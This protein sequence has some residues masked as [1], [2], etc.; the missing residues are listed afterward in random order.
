MR[1]FQSFVFILLIGCLPALAQETEKNEGA[2]SNPTR[3]ISMIK[4]SDSIYMFKGKGGNI[5]I[6]K[7]E[8]GVLM[9]D[10]QF[11]AVTP[12]ILNLVRSISK[13]PIQYLVNTHHHG[14]HTGGNINMIQ[15]GTVVYSHDNVRR[16]LE[17]KERKAFNEQNQAGFDKM[18]KELKASGNDVKAREKLKEGY[19]ERP[20]YEAPE[21]TFPMI[22]FSEDI[23]FYYNGEKVMVFHVH[24]AHTDGDAMVYFTDSNV[25]HSG[26]AF[27][28]GS[29]PFI[30]VNSGGTYKGYIAGIEKALMLIDEDT[31]IIPGHGDV[32][33]KADLEFSR[34]MMKALQDRVS[35]HYLSGKTKEEILGMKEITAEYDAKGF[36]D[37]FIST[38][39]FITLLYDITQ[40]K[41]GKRT[42]K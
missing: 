4:V 24:S 7:G 10:S 32:G 15:N 40:R 14:D 22:T 21:D 41:Y 8:D 29:Y 34:N 37:G 16:R 39:K 11:E 30:D 1:I 5:G 20:Q 33:R 9:V 2:A 27:V 6:F 17:D 28:N 31:R 36:G 13:K 12:E 42:N 23:T 25:L 35:Y 19:N 3:T 38:E 18:V 26:D